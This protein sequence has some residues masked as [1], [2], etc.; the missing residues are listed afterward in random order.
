MPRFTRRRTYRS[1]RKT[2]KAGKRYSR[3]RTSTYRPKFKKS[4]GLSATELKYVDCNSSTAVDCSNVFDY[5][6]HPNAFAVNIAGGSTVTTRTGNQCFVR[7]ITVRGQMCTKT[8]VTA[9][10]T[11]RII[12]FYDKN[13]IAGNNPAVTDL[14]DSAAANNVF[15][16]RNLT[17]RDRFVVLKDIRGATAP[18][19]QTASCIPF[20][21]SV[22]TNIRQTYG[23]ASASNVTS[24]G[25]YLAFVGENAYASSQITFVHS[26]R[27]RFTDP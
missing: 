18:A 17:F 10:P 3:R 14:L 20:E 2:P 6:T 5:T 23:D 16:P 24:G 9:Q 25:L 15:A 27:V 19:A 21:F 1:F 4:G 7:E 11:Y 8:G 13:G 22:K 12:L 26:T